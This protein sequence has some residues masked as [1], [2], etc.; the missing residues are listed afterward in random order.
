MPNPFVDAQGS[1]VLINPNF[2][3]RHASHHEQLWYRIIKL[4]ES[5]RMS[6]ADFD[7][8]VEDIV[9][10]LTYV[11]DPSIHARRQIGPW[12]IGYLALF[13]FVTWSYFKCVG[14]DYFK[15]PPPQSH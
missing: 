10:F 7:D 12:V 5:G 1:Q 13:I 8:Y 2:F 9:L 6:P 4:K 15:S 3:D 14:K 11:S